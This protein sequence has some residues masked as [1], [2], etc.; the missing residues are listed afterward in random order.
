MRVS[1][2]KHSI[3]GVPKTLCLIFRGQQRNS[4]M[5]PSHDMLLS[6]SPYFYPFVIVSFQM[7]HGGRKVES[8]EK[9]PTSSPGP[10]V[11]IGPKALGTRLAPK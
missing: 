11:I 10:F 9:Y 6:L 8:I 1:E 7:T 2:I 4:G 3:F 5:D